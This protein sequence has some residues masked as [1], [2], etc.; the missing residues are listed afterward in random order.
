MIVYDDSILKNFWAKVDH[1]SNDDCWL[2]TRGL[3]FS[4]YGQFHV[5]RRGLKAHRVA[6]EIT[7]G[8]IPAGL[9]VCHKCDNRKCVNPAHL[10]LGTNAENM[11]DRNAKGRQAGPVGEANRGAKIK[12]ADVYCIRLAVGKQSEIARRFG[13]SEAQVSRIRSGKNWAHL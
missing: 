10:F 2:W 7:Y 4:G 5:K 12:S 11:A 3:T 13:L 6:W 9:C 8:E 1:G